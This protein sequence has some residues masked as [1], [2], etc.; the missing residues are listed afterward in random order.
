MRVFQDQLMMSMDAGRRIYF[1]AYGGGP[2]LEY[3]PT[4][5]IPRLRTMG[6]EEKT[7]E[8]IFIHNPSRFL[9]LALY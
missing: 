7:I 6:I 2:G 5:I 3:I 4:V 8:K 1:K 9:G